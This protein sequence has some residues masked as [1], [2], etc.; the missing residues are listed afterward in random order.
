MTGFQIRLCTQGSL[1]ILFTYLFAGLLYACEIVDP[2]W[3][4]QALLIIQVKWFRSQFS[5]TLGRL[6]TFDHFGG[7]FSN[8]I[9]PISSGECFLFTKHTP[10]KD[11]YNKLARKDTHCWTIA[12]RKKESMKEERETS[13]LEVDP[14]I[15]KES[16][17]ERKN[18]KKSSQSVS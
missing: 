10:Y 12:V 13:K 9:R 11:Y 5:L 4:H 8:S 7:N 18:M 2:S 17:S 6:A 14:P 16:N 15:K 1:S 3:S